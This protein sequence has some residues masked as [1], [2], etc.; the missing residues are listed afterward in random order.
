MIKSPKISEA[1]M[2]REGI[3]E[4]KQLITSMPLS[5]INTLL[6]DTSLESRDIFSLN[7]EHAV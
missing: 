5:L 2:S 1:V 7:S 6:N 4:K 3:S